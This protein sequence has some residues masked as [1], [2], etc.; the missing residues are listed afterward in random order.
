MENEGNGSSQWKNS[1]LEDW[2]EKFQD[3]KL[4]QKPRIG[5]KIL[6][7][8]ID[9]KNYFVQKMEKVVLSSEKFCHWKNSKSE[10]WLQEF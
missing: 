7:Q 3:G 8:K 4:V 9:M 10:N 2:G 1:R 6:Y 5:K